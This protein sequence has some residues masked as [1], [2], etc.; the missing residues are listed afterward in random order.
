MLYF[1]FLLRELKWWSESQTI[2]S[3]VGHFAL[4]YQISNRLREVSQTPGTLELAEKKLNIF[5]NQNKC[6]K[7]SY[8]GAVEL[9]CQSTPSIS[10]LGA[11]VLYRYDTS[12]GPVSRKSR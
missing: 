7:F 3:D 12:L 4:S 5:S 2:H 8:K 9:R 6:G 11:K 10:I 1:Y